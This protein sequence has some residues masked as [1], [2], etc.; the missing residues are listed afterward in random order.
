MNNDIQQYVQHETT[1]SP[2]PVGAGGLESANNI[3]LPKSNS[4]GSM[5]GAKFI[6]FVD[7][8]FRYL[9]MSSTPDLVRRTRNV[10]LDCTRR[11][12]RGDVGYT[13]LSRIILIRVRQ[14]V[15]TVHWERAQAF[16][17]LSVEWRRTK[18]V[19]AARLAGSTNVR[20]HQAQNQ[21]TQQKQRQQ[22]NM[23]TICGPTWQP[24]LQSTASLSPTHPS[25]TVGLSGPGP[26]QQQSIPSIDAILLALSA[27]EECYQV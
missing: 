5:K 6:L 2:I 19:T 11:N 18:H 24:H 20:N 25:D 1:L 10:I 16:F 17:R 12:R 23:M 9:E 27:A 15:G 7:A 22:V 26:I 21:L 8:L 14:T 3:L 13:P 4:R